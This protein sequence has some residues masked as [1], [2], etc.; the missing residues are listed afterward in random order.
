MI[1]F[2]R[3]IEP[4]TTKAKHTPMLAPFRLKFCIGWLDEIYLPVMERRS[5]SASKKSVEESK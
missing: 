4:S 3:W 2:G 1:V 5:A